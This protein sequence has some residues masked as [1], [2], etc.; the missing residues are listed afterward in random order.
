MRIELESQVMREETLLDSLKATPRDKLVYSCPRISGR[1]AHFPGGAKK[2]CGA[3][4]DHQTE[5]YGLEHPELLNYEVNWKTSKPSRQPG[6]G[7][8]LGWTAAS[9]LF[10]SN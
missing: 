9:P 6:G 3:G 10:G 8:L 5:D 1:R 7:H 2:S 4:A